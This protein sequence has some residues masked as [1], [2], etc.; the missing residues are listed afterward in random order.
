MK[1]YQ[2]KHGADYYV[3]FKR[4]DMCLVSR[5]LFTPSEFN[6]LCKK[7]GRDLSSRFNIV[8]VS[9][10]RPVWCFGCRWLPEDLGRS[11]TVY[12]IR[13]IS[14]KMFENQLISLGLPYYYEMLGSKPCEYIDGSGF[15]R[16]HINV[17]VDYDEKKKVDEI[18]L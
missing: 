2:V 5:E 16:N 3:H 10:N 13:K 9:K 7:A 12:S 18:A 4:T 8:F 1:Y 11:W 17:Y 6:R 14:A 15:I